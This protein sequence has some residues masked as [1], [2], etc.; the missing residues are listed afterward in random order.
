MSNE[1]RLGTEPKPDD[2]ARAL[3]VLY[4]LV[5]ALPDGGAKIVHESAGFRESVAPVVSA[6]GFD[7]P[8]HPFASPPTDK[9]RFVAMLTG[10][11]TGHGTRVDHEDGKPNGETV[12]IEAWKFGDEGFGRAEF[13]FDRH[14]RFVDPVRV[15]DADGP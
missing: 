15:A 10:A 11:G 9:E 14:G 3:D 13:S 1:R 7:E 5:K 4:R 12:T 8:L 2:V 6:M